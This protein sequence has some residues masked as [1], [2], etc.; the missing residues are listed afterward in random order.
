MKLLEG[1]IL[2]E[3]DKGCSGETGKSMQS[4]KKEH[5]QYIRLYR[6]QGPVSR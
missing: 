5:N 4:K 2:F 6:T 1:Y 3:C